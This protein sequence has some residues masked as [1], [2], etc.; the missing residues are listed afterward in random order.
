MP[1]VPS[2]T[3]Y[4]D[5]DFDL[6]GAVIDQLVGAFGELGIGPLDPPS[7][8]SV[9]AGYGI[10]QLYLDTQLVYIG[11]AVKLQKRLLEH[12]RK[13]SGRK[14]IDQSKVGFKCLSVDR[15][16]VQVTH[17]R[18]LIEHSPGCDWNGKGFGNHDYGKERDNT[19]PQVFDQTY[20]IN[21]R[22]RCAAVT[23]GEWEANDLLVAMK[24][25]LPY[26]F[27]YQTDS[28]QG[29]WRKGSAAYN[30]LRVTVPHPGMPAIDLLR[31][32]V[33]Q[34]PAGWQAII[35]P[36]H[37]ILYAENRDYT[38]SIDVVRNT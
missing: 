14:N 31:E 28:P 8:R 7:L 2:R 27:R 3:P 24:E 4:G 17:E 12:H 16:W 1:A 10:Y 35:F 26:T 15:A 13:L 36:G 25:E 6:A 11:S 21:E 30:G 38:H 29:G 22:W 20:P 32:I 34:F 9:D 5:F 18:Q 33:R 19:K 23:A 37:M